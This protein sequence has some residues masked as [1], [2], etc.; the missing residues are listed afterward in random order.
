MEFNYRTLVNQHQRRVY[1]LAHHMLG[2]AQEAED[3]TQEVYI[4][5]WKRMDWVVLDEARPWLLHVTRNLCIDQLRKRKPNVEMEVEPACDRTENTPQGSLERS[6]LSGWLKA[7]IAK[8]KEP[9]KSLVLMADLQ[10]LSIKEI[11]AIKEFSENQV[12]V[13]LHR[14]RKQLRSLLQNVEL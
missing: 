10:Q 6:Q 8:L 11:A 9:Y 12:K 5:L 1:S 13:Y 14:A 3:V 7:S 2:D 4:R